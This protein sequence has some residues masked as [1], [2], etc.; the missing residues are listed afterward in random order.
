V[1]ELHQA[2][3]GQHVRLW[4]S[5]E[6]LQLVRLAAATQLKD[7]LRAYRQNQNVLYA[8][9][10]YIYHALTTPNDPKFT[11]LWGLQNTGQNLGTFGADIHATQAWGLTTGSSSVVVAVIDTGVDYN[12]EDLTA[13]VWSTHRPIPQP[14]MA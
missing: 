7:A 10:N 11:Q 3:G 13:N 2:V 14:S 4:S 6:G 9:P 8:E 1:E 5:V 12:H